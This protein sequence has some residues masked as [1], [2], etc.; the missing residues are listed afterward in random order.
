MAERDAFGPIMAMP[1]LIINDRSSNYKYSEPVITAA[2]YQA[3]AEVAACA[4]CRSA[5]REATK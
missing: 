1:D 5:D 3:V 4:N 2:I